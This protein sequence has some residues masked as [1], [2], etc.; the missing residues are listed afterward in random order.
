[1]EFFNRKEEVIELILTPHGKKKLRDG[2]FNPHYY[3]FADST[4]LYDCRHAGFTG[5]QNEL[6]E[7]LQ[8]LPI[9]KRATHL[10][11]DTNFN[12][13]HSLNSCQL[14]TSEF[15]QQKFPAFEL[16]VYGGHI[17]TGSIIYTSSNLIN[18]EIPRLSINL[19]NIYDFDNT[20]FHQQEELLIELNELNGV[21]EKENFEFELFKLHN[22][23]ETKTKLSFVNDELAQDEE[24]YEIVTDIEPDKIEYWFEILTDNRIS[25]S[26]IFSLEEK[27][28][29]PYQLLPNTL[30]GSQ[31]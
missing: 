11:Q 13:L 28:N 1:M 18:V 22:N 31:C 26:I 23:N 15:G 14:G 12:E 8:E 7:R 19:Y 4:M 10:S 29:N 3:S 21:F 25:E 16:K 2:E 9:P 17:V 27:G 5:T 6:V 24:Y 20:E 30:S